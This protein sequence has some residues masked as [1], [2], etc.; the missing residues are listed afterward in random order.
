MVYN[1]SHFRIT[2]EIYGFENILNF[3]CWLK[4]SIQS[5]SVMTTRA[6]LQCHYQ[7]K[8]IAPASILNYLTLPIGLWRHIKSTL[9]LGLCR[10]GVS[11]LSVLAWVHVH[12]IS[13]TQRTDM[14]K[15]MLSHDITTKVLMKWG[16]G[17]FFFF[18]FFLFI[19]LDSSS[20]VTFCC[21]SIF[22]LLHSGSSSGGFLQQP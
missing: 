15:A 21:Y 20:K 22:W 10:K 16:S 8:N 2:P 1:T 12:A 4:M 17:S 9:V 18:F 14:E 19:N 6:K 5:H 11:V 3:L 7:A 13:W